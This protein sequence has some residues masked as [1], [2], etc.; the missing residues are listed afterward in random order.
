MLDWIRFKVIDQRNTRAFLLP[1]GTTDAIIEKLFDLRAL[2][3]LNRSV[4]AAHRPGER[5]VVYKLD[6]GCYVGLTNTGKFPSGLFFRDDP[7]AEINFDVPDDDARSYRRAIL[8]LD[9]FYKSLGSEE[10]S[11]NTPEG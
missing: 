11:A 7:A 5:Y 2:H 3:I 1:V 8:D 6:Y 9:E 4:S 10:T